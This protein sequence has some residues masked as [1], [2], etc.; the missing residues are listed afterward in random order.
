MLLINRS[1]ILLLRTQFLATDQL[2]NNNEAYSSS[3]KEQ[4]PATAV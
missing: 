2:R 4:F 3:G 1:Q